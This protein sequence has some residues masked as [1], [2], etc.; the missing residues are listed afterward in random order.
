MACTTW[1]RRSGTTRERQAL[2]EATGVRVLRVRAEDVEADI[3]SVLSV[4]RESL[5]LREECSQ[6]ESAL[7]PKSGLALH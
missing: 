6:V 4:I 3:D 5:T 1:L 7:P 2:I